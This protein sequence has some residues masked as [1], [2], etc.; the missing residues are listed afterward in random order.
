MDNLSEIKPQDRKRPILTDRGDSLKC[1]KLTEWMKCAGYTSFNNS[2]H[3]SQHMKRLAL[4]IQ[5]RFVKESKSTE[6]ALS[7]KSP[8]LPS[9]SI[10]PFFRGRKRRNS[11][12]FCPISECAASSEGRNRFGN[13][14]FCREHLISEYPGTSE[15][16][17][18][19]EALGN[20]EKR[21][22]RVSV[23]VAVEEDM[24]QSAGAASNCSSQASPPPRNRF[25]REIR[26]MRRD[27]SSGKTAKR[28]PEGSMDMVDE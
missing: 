6:L 17:R 25:L 21:T 18:E 14:K 8:Q 3:D 13:A 20:S 15:I 26:R 23:L 22:E 2:F 11:R 28:T 10:A 16:E 1:R 27:S 5:E 12:S 4:P 7:T 19:L 9:I 24:G